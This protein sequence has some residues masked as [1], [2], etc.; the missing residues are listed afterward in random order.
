[1]K[2]STNPRRTRAFTLIELLAVIAILGLIAAFAVPQ[3]LK[4]VSGARSDSAR[5]QI[6][7]LG[8]SIDLYRLEVGSF[9]PNLEALVEKP[10]G[11][12]KWNGPYL[13]KKTIPKDPWGNDYIYR[14]PGR[15]G[16]YDL[17][18]L[19]ADNAEGGEGEQKDIVSWE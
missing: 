11:V 2:P 13:K 16:P 17:L 10:A 12:E 14:Y 1:M 9:P 8:A 4:W 3:V 15:N 19:G 18:S 5:I 7:A 6:E